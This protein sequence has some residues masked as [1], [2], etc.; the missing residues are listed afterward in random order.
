MLRPFLLAVFSLA[1]PAL[2]AQPP[3]HDALRCAAIYGRTAEA[4]ESAGYLS[5][6]DVTRMMA[7]R[8]VNTHVSGPSEARQAAYRRALANTPAT[9]WPLPE[10][11]VRVL[12]ACMAD[13]PG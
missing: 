6:L 3:Q 10:S 2:A 4:F 1:T 8:L 5:T 13:F 7:A 9:S 11:H 12:D